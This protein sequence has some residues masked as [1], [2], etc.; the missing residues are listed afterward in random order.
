MIKQFY[1]INNVDLFD[2]MPRDPIQL[3]YTI[4]QFDHGDNGDAR[5]KWETPALSEDNALKYLESDVT[6]AHGQQDGGG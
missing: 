6:D 1:D 2:N 5:A 3:D 4:P